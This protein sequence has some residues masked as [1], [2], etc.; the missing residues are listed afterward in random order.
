TTVVN[1]DNDTLTGLIISNNRTLAM[2]SGYLTVIGGNN[3]FITR[4]TLDPGST[5]TFSFNVSVRNFGVFT[6]QGA[7]VNYSSNGVRF[8]VTGTPG[9][10]AVPPPSFLSSVVA[11]EYAAISGAGAA[12]PLGFLTVQIIP[13]FYAFELIAV[14]VL[15][16]DVF[17]EVRAFRRWR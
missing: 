13:G 10:L 9:K 15:L 11:I 3:T 16:L 6:L 17:L 4:A 5:V 8:N 7:N 12:S 1:N 2:Y 14:L